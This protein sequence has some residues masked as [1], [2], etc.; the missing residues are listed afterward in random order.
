MTDDGQPTDPETTDPEQIDPQP[1][2]VEPADAA[3]ADAEP[4]VPE[5]PVPE[6]VTH[7]RASSRRPQ[8][9]YTPYNVTEKELRRRRTRKQLRRRRRIAVGVFLL[10]FFAPAIYS[11]ATTM[12]EPSSLPMGIRTIEWVREHHG[13][14]FVNT[15]ERYYYT[16][17]APKKGGPG[18]KKIPTVGLRNDNGRPKPKSSEK[19][20]Y[21]PPN[22]R[23]V[24]KPGLANEGVWREV[25][26]QIA[27]R[28]RSWSRTSVPIPTTRASSPTWPGST[29]RAPNWPCT[30]AATSRPRAARAAR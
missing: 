2:D 24:I 7:K 1:T 16:W 23:P 27:A 28:R 15:V 21:R 22:I 14:W 30:P 5:P 11:W 19:P 3:P 20:A 4:P 13:A 10:I 29:P 8:P 18:I 6:P 25:V 9:V 26:K 12:A 17:T